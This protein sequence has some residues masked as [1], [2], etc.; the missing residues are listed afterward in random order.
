MPEC[1]GWIDSQLDCRQGSL[2]SK[3]AA[4]AIALLLH[5]YLDRFSSAVREHRHAA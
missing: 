1:L 3:H 4:A 2:M 5:F